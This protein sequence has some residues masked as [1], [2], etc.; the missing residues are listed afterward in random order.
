MN[1]VSRTGDINLPH[2]LPP[3]KYLFTFFSRHIC[4]QSIGYFRQSLRCFVEEGVLGPEFH[5]LFVDW[6]IVIKCKKQILFKTKSERYTPRM[7]ISIWCYTAVL[8]PTVYAIPVNPPLLHGSLPRKGLI[9]RM[10]WVSCT[11]DIN[12]PHTPFL[13]HDLP[14]TKNLFTFFSRHICLQSFDY[15]NNNRFHIPERKV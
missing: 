15:V 13:P 5:L 14:P 7:Y 1:W 10:D 4:L 2:D 11:G 3:T 6:D 9:S 12:L 8:N